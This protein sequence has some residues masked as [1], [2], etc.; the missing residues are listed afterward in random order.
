MQRLQGWAG[1]LPSGSGTDHQH[2]PPHHMPSTE[3]SHPLNS[4]QPWN[5][6][7][8]RQSVPSYPGQQ[9]SYGSDGARCP[10]AS[11]RLS[12]QRRAHQRPQP[13]QRCVRSWARRFQEQ[14]SER[15]SSHQVRAALT[16]HSQPP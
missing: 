5:P 13:E 7:D 8:V 6:G 15:S 1:R 10:H 3:Q 4:H 16:V 14:R 12:R 11:W 2:S 9:Q